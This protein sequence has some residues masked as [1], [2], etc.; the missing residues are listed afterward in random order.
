V[1]YTY[2]HIAFH[3]SISWSDD[4]KMWNKSGVSCLDY[5]VLNGRMIKE[6][7]ERIWKGIVMLLFEV[8]W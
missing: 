5:K 6:L 1:V 8:L 3:G 7:L 2:I 4:H